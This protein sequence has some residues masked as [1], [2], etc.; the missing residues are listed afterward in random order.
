LKEKRRE[1]KKR[2]LENVEI[3]CS[4]GEVHGSSDSDERR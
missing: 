3:G 1:K 4:V 2:D